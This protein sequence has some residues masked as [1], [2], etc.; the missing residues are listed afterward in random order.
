M[1]TNPLTPANL[2]EFLA[3]FRFNFTSEDEL[4]RGLDEALAR[5]GAVFERE[6]RLDAR[7]RLDFLVAPERGAAVTPGIGIEVKVGGSNAEL[8]TQ[9]HR[10]VLRPEVL[11]LV[12]VTS[13]AQHRIPDTLNGKPLALLHVSLTW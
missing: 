9:L 7:N 11:G 4:Q 1:Q 13:R 5:H 10:Y 2:R 12:V 8:L 6:Y 3:G